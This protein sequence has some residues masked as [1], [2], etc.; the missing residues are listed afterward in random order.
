MDEESRCDLQIAVMLGQLAEIVQHHGDAVAVPQLAAEGKTFMVEAAGLDNLSSVLGEGAEVAQR[1]GLVSKVAR[2][3]L[4]R[5]ALLVEPPRL[6][7]VTTAR[8]EEGEV[9]QHHPPARVVVAGQ[10][11]QGFL[12]GGMRGRMV[13]FIFGD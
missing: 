1:R 8:G 6:V 4:V 13:A 7:T 2:G 9:V 10:Q 3:A 11:A 12:K 5:E